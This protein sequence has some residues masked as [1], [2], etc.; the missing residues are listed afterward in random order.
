M[1][2]GP[3]RFSERAASLPWAKGEEMRSTEESRSVT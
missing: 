3:A 1:E 2:L